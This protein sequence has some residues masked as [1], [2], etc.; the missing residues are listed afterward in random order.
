MAE[1]AGAMVVAEVTT[2]QLVPQGA[3]RMQPGLNS[4]AAFYVRRRRRSF[5]V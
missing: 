5:V 2:K 1:E 3:T 4:R